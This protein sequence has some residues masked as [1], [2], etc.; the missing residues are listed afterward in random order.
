MLVLIAVFSEITSY[1]QFI[2][3]RNEKIKS[4]LVTGENF[5]DISKNTKYLSAF[6][7]SLNHTAYFHLISLD[8]QVLAIT[9]IHLTKT[10]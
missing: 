3:G 8:G 10:F 4:T 7:Y 1:S 5:T 9:V 2:D 6:K